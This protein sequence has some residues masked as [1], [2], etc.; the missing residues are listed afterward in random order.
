MED[1]GYNYNYNKSLKGFASANRSKMTKSEVYMW[2]YHL[3]RGQLNGYKF[4]R[5]RPV[6]NYIADF[7]CKELM[8]IIEVDGITHLEDGADIR[9]AERTKNLE[10]VG[11]RV[12]RFSS[13]E[14]LNR[15][16]DVSV[17]LN[18]I[19]EELKKELP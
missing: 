4:L 1:K 17:R 16:G 10:S 9:D 8:L 11:F 15:R 5:Q 18:S 14:V 6:L 3:S 12:E 13:W 2:K 7:M 19:V